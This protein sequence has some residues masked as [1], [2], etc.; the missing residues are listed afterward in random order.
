MHGILMDHQPLARTNESSAR[1]AAEIGKKEL[2]VT[3]FRW[4][5]GWLTSEISR[6][7]TQ[8]KPTGRQKMNISHLCRLFG[9]QTTRQM[10]AQMETQKGLSSCDISGRLLNERY[11]R[12]GPRVMDQRGGTTLNAS[13]LPTTDQI[14]EF[15]TGVIGVPWEKMT[16][17]LPL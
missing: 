8:S 16:T 2:A 1:K 6:R 9:P 10:E 5:I 7:K 13:T 15:W 12:Q 11:R 14:T 3:Q 17:I 4:K